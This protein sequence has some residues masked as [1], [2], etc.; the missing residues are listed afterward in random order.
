[1]PLQQLSD[2]CTAAQGGCRAGQVTARDQTRVS[3]TIPQQ[4]A[5][6]GRTTLLG[7]LSAKGPATSAHSDCARARRGA[8]ARLRAVER[9][10]AERV[11]RRV[12][13]PGVAQ[14]QL[15]AH[16]VLAAGAAQRPRAA[17]A[18]H[19]RHARVVR[20][21]LA[22]APRARRRRRRRRGR[23]WRPARP[24]ASQAACVAC[25]TLACAAPHAGTPP[26]LHPAHKQ[27]SCGA[28]RRPRLQQQGLVLDRAGHRGSLQA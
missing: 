24:V 5:M 28:P 23:A 21:R 19:G 17:Q 7:L 13:Q 14:I 22:P 15:H 8:A 10:D 18:L 16:G 11:A 6:R 12:G 25:L 27:H 20:P 26:A 3:V 1:M 9:E 2:P 4:P